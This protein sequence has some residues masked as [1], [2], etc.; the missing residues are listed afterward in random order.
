MLKS[1][2]AEGDGQYPRKHSGSKTGAEAVSQL[3]PQFCGFL[4]LHLT[5]GLSHDLK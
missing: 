1:D 5:I 4:E 3:Q 2:K